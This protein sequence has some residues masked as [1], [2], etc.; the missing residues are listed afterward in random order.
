MLCALLTGCDDFLDENIRAEYTTAGLAHVLALSG[1]HLAVIAMIL[2]LLLIPLRMVEHRR[3]AGAVLLACM[4]GYV[5][6]TGAS[7]SVV[8]ACLMVSIVAFGRFASMSGNPL[9]SLCVA[10]ILI[11]ILIPRHFSCPVFS[12][13]LRPW[14]P[15]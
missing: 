6:L 14:A 12:F 8:R 5:A 15:F 11:L 9:N 7:P 13:R 4:W 2:G 3:A 10:G 1:T